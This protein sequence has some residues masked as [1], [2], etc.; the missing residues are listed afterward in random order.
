MS[1][2]FAAADRPLTA[3]GRA[4]FGCNWVLLWL[5][6]CYKKHNDIAPKFYHKILARVK[7][8]CRRLSTLNCRWSDRFHNGQNYIIYHDTAPNSRTYIVLGS[9]TIW[10]LEPSTPTMGVRLSGNPCQ[11]ENFE[12]V[13]H[14]ISAKP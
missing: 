2:V 9:I 3:T 8:K 1:S 11:V 13:R 4:G 7:R 5:L 10:V 12:R 14:I 6:Y